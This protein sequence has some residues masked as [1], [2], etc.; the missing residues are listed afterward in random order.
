[1][2]AWSL[3]ADEFLGLRVTYS[4]PFHTQTA[5]KEP[6]RKEPHPCSLEFAD[7]IVDT[8]DALI[9]VLD[10]RGHVIRINKACEA[11]LG[12]SFA[13]VSHAPIWETVAMP[14]DVPPLMAM[15][16]EVQAFLFPYRR[17]SVWIAK[18]GRQELIAWTNTALRDA[19]GRVQAVIATGLLMTEQRAAEQALIQAQ[20]NYQSI[21]ENAVDGIFQ[22]TPAGHYLSAN[23][24][25]ARIYGYSS[26]KEMIESLRNI[27]QQLYVNPSRRSDFIQLMQQQD[28]VSNFE[29]EI[30]RRDGS[31]IWIAEHARVVRDA[32]G[33]VLYYEGTVQDITLRKG[34]EAERERLLADALERADY[35]PLTGLM[36]HRAFQRRCTEEAACAR[37]EGTPLAVAIFDI[38]N[39]KYF[40]DAHG[41]L[42]GDELLR[43]IALTLQ[44]HCRSYDLLARYGSD[45]FALLMPRTTPESAARLTRRL[46]RT[47]EKTSYRSVGSD[48]AIPLS[49]TLGLAQLPQDA[50]GHESI[51]EAA[52]ARLARMKSNGRGDEEIES[53]RTLLHGSV[54][55][56]S[57]LD[58]L[59]IAVDNKDRYTRRH[60]EDVMRHAL[61]I[62]QSMEMPQ[63]FQ[64]T[65]QIAALLHDVGK[66]GVPDRILRKPDRLTDEEFEAIRQ[67]PLMG[68]VIVGAVPGF[69]ETLGAI[70][71][72]HE[73]WDGLGYPDNLRGEASP[74]PARIMAVADA[75][76]A[77]TMDRPYR[78]GKKPQEALAVLADG[79]GSQWDPACV[80]AFLSARSASFQRDRDEAAFCQPTQ[81]R[82][83]C[84]G[85]RG[86]A[87]PVVQ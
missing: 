85:S 82:G 10:C 23:P 78:K 55:G 76:S 42:T 68:A 73:R 66:I 53:L 64:R 70:R 4:V 5:Q 12:Y 49:L 25:L 11:A 28:S 65:I 17:E 20:Q 29:A 77:M 81:Q 16:E 45:E 40:N 52:S 34:L 74:L 48:T 37:R 62:A 41:H 33:S 22:T 54:Q 50:A 21:F 18:D 27:T 31:R 84:F 60:S 6:D 19:A 8:V 63:A 46:L 26:P 86:V 35:D 57:M 43:Q 38:D 15:F 24:S 39:F 72:H 1:V 69:E 71:H 7:V 87:R 47:V 13:E 51:L 32:A 59:V 58:A 67:H 44:R 83:Q 3:L 80:A 9:L 14:E 79:A 61:Q 36:N 56:F 2:T 75:Y 30:T